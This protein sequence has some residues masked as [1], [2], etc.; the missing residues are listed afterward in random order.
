MQSA[1]EVEGFVGGCWAARLLREHRALRRL[2]G[3]ISRQMG[4]ESL[5]ATAGRAV[6]Q[7]FAELAREMRG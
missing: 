6:E 3:I 2:L 4:S 1:V 7:A 5:E